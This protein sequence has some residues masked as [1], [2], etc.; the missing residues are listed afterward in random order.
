[1]FRAIFNKYDNLPGSFVVLG[2]EA[3]KF[4]GNQISI[5]ATAKGF[6]E[7]R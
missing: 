1:M 5:Y 2:S 7:F 4:G 3:A 6:V